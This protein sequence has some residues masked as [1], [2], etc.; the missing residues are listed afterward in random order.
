MEKKYFLNKLTIFK[1]KNFE[2]YDYSLVPDNF[3]HKDKIPIICKKHGVFYQ[4]S[5][6]HIYI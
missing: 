6:Y 4:R 5:I 2:I 1:P 3:H